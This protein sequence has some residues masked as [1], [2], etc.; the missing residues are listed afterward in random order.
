M[1]KIREK[2]NAQI[3]KHADYLTSIGMAMNV[4]KT[5]AVVFSQNTVEPITLNVNGSSFSTTSTMKVL[6]VIFNSKMHWN[7]QAGKAIASAKRSLYGLCILRRNLGS[8]GFTKILTVQFFSKLYYGAAVWLPHLSSSVLVRIT[9]LHYSAIRIA[10]FDYKNKIPR[11][12]LEHDFKCATPN[13]WQEHCVSREFVRIYRS[14]SPTSLFKRLDSHA[15][16]LY[17]SSPTRFFDKSTRQ[18]GKQ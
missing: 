13:E 6:G 12:V 18:V 17:R 14:S 7:I 3:K 2:G 5:E 8:L 4:D 15:Y 1:C 16:R 9:S 11:E 10:C